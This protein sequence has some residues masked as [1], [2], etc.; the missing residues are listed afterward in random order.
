MLS[1]HRERN[2]F[3]KNRERGAFFDTQWRLPLPSSHRMEVREV[4][5]AEHPL[6][7]RVATRNRTLAHGH[8]V[9]LFLAWR[10][11]YR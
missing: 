8:R 3:P 10:L 4:L 9:A 5:L 2:M 11:P 6:Q 7:T 1:N